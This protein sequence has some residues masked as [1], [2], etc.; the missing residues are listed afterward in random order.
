MFTGDDE[1]RAIGRLFQRNIVISLWFR[2]HFN[3]SPYA[4]PAHGVL[5]LRTFVSVR[6]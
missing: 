4:P 3:C 2:W 6:P 5:V 1:R